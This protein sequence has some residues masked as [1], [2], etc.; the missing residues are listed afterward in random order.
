MRRAPSPKAF[1][2]ARPRKRFISGANRSGPSTARSPS[3]RTSS[4]PA[5]D[6]A[7]RPSRTVKAPSPAG[8]WRAAAKSVS[9]SRPAGPGAAA[10][11]ELAS[12]AGA[13]SAAAVASASSSSHFVTICS[14]P[15]RRNQERAR[16]KSPCSSQARPR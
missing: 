16:S 9:R 4:S 7:A 8:T 6:T 13:G 12:A 11:R 15:E 5:T 14:L 1:S 10:R 3:A 2:V